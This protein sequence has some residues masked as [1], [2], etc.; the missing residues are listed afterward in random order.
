VAL[1]VLLP[2]IVLII[3]FIPI[4]IIF[5]I[6][7]RVIIIVNIYEL[8]ISSPPVAIARPSSA[9]LSVYLCLQLLLQV[10]FVEIELEVQ[11]FQVVYFFLQ[12]C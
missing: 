2:P 3:V 12:G 7:L 9:V 5:I 10:V 6:I 1:V 8:H 11:V 4:A